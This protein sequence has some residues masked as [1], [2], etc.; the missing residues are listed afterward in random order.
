[1]SMFTLQF[2]RQGASAEVR[3]SYD[4]QTNK[5]TKI[6]HK[7]DAT[8]LQGYFK[9]IKSPS[10]GPACYELT[11]PPMHDAMAYT[12]GARLTGVR[13]GAA[14]GLTGDAPQMIVSESDPDK[15]Y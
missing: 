4:P 10:L 8:L 3:V 14:V 1:M 12:V 11:N 15:V 7:G 5:V 13:M 2:T 9:T 6:E